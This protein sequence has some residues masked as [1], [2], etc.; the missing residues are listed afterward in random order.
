[1]QVLYEQLIEKGELSG[2]VLFSY[3]SMIGNLTLPLGFVAL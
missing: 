3:K 2:R 1:M